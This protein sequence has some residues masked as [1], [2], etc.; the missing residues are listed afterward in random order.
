MKPSFKTFLFSFVLLI[1]LLDA[2]ESMAQ[3]SVC[4]SN[5]SSAVNSSQKKTGLGLNNGIFLLLVMPYAIVGIVGVVYYTNSRKKKRIT[6][7]EL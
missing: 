6:N 5:V 2:S 1:G 7:C 3:C 4:A